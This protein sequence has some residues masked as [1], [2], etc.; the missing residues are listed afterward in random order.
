ME[1]E[2]IYRSKFKKNFEKNK[3]CS[4]NKEYKDKNMLSYELEILHF[5][6][7]LVITV[8]IQVLGTSVSH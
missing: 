5:L 8:W 6:V 7:V 4:A 1:N 2:E 3:K